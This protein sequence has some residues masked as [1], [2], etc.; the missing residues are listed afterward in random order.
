MARNSS[1]NKNTL[2]LKAGVSLGY[3]PDV[4]FFVFIFSL[5]KKVCCKIIF[6]N[7]CNYLK[8]QEIIFYCMNFSS[9]FP[10]GISE[11]FNK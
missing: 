11:N 7:I 6:A 2:L 10:R 8:Q 1:T 4:F 9:D 5:K 3:N